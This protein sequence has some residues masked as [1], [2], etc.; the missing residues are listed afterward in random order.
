MPLLEG[1]LAVDLRPK[2]LRRGA[3]RLIFGLELEDGLGRPVTGDGP[4]AKRLTEPVL[5]KGCGSEVRNNLAP[6][7]AFFEADGLLRLYCCDAFD[8]TFS[9]AGSE[10][11]SFSARF[12]VLIAPHLSTSL[13]IWP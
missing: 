11:S 5:K 12:P 13:G 9:S 10:L 8:A 7:A 6:C 2:I 1:L 3:E 4:S